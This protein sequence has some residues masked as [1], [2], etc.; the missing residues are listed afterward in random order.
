MSH[1]NNLAD[2]HSLVRGNAI[3]RKIWHA[4]YA[5]SAVLPAGVK[6]ADRQSREW[7]DMSRK[8]YRIELKMDFNDDTRHEA[9]IMVAKQYARD[10]LASAMLLQDGRQPQVA[11][12]TDDTFEGMEKISII[13]ESENVHRPSTD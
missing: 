1:L 3:F 4:R 6:D 10:L 7:D 9:L 12:I 8:T 13:E 2:D 11:L 5:F